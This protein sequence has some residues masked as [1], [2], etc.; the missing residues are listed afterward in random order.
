MIYTK[1]RFGAELIIFLEENRY[2][3]KAIVRW[4]DKIYHDHVGDFDEELHP[5]IQDIS[6]MCCDAQFIQTESQLY[7]LA[8]R[9]IKGK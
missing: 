4:A 2:N 5:I 8:I 7:T 1:R 6:S 9:L 3:V